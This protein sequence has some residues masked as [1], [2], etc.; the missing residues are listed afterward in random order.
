MRQCKCERTCSCVDVVVC[1]KDYLSEVII[2]WEINDQD[3]PSFR[4][5]VGHSTSFA[6][7]VSIDLAFIVT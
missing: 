4:E 3:M 1:Y 6:L 2:S 7:L 5:T